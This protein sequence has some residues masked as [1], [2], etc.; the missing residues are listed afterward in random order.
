[1]GDK[2]SQIF[3]IKSYKNNRNIVQLGFLLTIILIGY[4]FTSFVSYLEMGLMP[5]V[6]RPPGVEGFLPISAL[7][8]LK[9]FLKTGIV[10]D[11]HPSGLII[12]G[13]ITA[14]SLLVKKGFCSWVC[15]IGFISEFLLK[16]HYRIFKNG[17]KVNRFIDYFLRSIKYLLLL[18]FIWTVFYKM[19]IFAIKQFLYSPYNVVSDIKMLDFFVNISPL[20]LTI[21][22][23]ILILSVLI[24]NFWCRYLC[25]Y[26][27]YLGF[28]S[29]LS[30]FKIRRDEESCTSCNKCDKKCPSN[31]VI[32]NQNTV[33]SDECIACGSCIDACPEKNTLKLS[34][35]GKKAALKPVMI[36]VLVIMMFLGGS[37]SARI[38]GVWQ[39]SVTDQQYINYMLQTGL[40]DI[41]NI[42]D[43]RG[44]ID[45]LD[46]NGKKQLMM[47]MMRKKN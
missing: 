44:F 21:F 13:L 12:F 41:S 39:N 31:I 40:I 37:I 10:N 26:G 8:S 43:L 46:K 23:A 42:K 19:N 30:P 20:A 33:I 47:Q 4:N 24:K 2:K 3:S 17:L 9:Y 14:I 28:L 22:L 45:K 34:L 16:I 35:P 38:S 32:S 25:P 11:I 6:Q 29:F 27:A 1:M 18:F 7:I 36:S 15:P 5:D